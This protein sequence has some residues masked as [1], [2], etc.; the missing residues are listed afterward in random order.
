LKRD[1]IVSLVVLVGTIALYLSLGHIEM[2]GARIFPRIIIIIMGVLSALLLIQSALQKALGAKKAK[3]PVGR[4]FTCFGLIIV[5]FVF[6]ESVGFY[7]S[8]FL[9]FVAV[10][11]ILGRVDLTLRT[12]LVRAGS[13]LAFTIV[14]FILFD[15]LL[16]AQTPRGVLM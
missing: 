6:M 9:F 2:E 14:L 5:Y 8:A 10:T 13:G 4:F 7:L 11:F 15:L 1:V 16:K 3:F 12:G